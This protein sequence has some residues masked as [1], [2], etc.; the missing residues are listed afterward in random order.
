MR[1]LLVVALALGCAVQPTQEELNYRED[2]QER[3]TEIASKLV[4]IEKGLSAAAFAKIEADA[5]QEKEDL[6]DLYW[7]DPEW[8]YENKVRVIAQE[9]WEAGM[10]KWI[11]GG[12]LM[13]ILGGGVY[14]GNRY[15]L[16]R[17]KNGTKETDE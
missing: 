2:A 7:S 8:G 6:A 12:G 11:K 15:R 10:W 3:Q 17:K 9:E 4:S 1:W 5:K 14:G 13:L 16:Y